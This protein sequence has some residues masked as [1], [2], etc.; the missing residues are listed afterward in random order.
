MH[1]SWQVQRLIWMWN[2]Y[3][4]LLFTTYGYSLPSPPDI[5]IYKEHRAKFSCFS[6][7]KPFR[8][9]REDLKHFSFVVTFKSIPLLW[10]LLLFQIFTLC[11]LSS[12]L[13]QQDG[14]KESCEDPEIGDHSCCLSERDDEFNLWTAAE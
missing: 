6:L 13:E 12:L 1:S 4:F 8:L 7:L 3:T 2:I 9:H 5:N 10:K 14:Q 11:Q